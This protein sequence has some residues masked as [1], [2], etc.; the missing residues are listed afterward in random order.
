MVLDGEDG[1]A[2]EAQA[3]IGAVE[4]GDVSLLDA[5]RKGGGIDGKTMVHRDDLDLA[6]R[7]VLHR[8][9]GAV[10]ALMH[11]FG[12][13]AKRQAQH[14]VTEADAEDRN[15]GLDQFPDDRDG[16]FPSC[17]RVSR[18][19]RKEDSIRIQRKHIV[20]ARRR[21]HDGDLAVE[22]GEEAQDVTLHA[23]IDADDMVLRSVR[24]QFGSAFVPD[25][26]LFA[27]GGRLTRCRDLGEIE[28]F[29]AAPV[30]RHR[31]QR[32]DVELPVRIMSDNGIR[33]AVFADPGCQGAGVD[34][35]HADNPAGLQPR[36]EMAHG[37]V[38]GRIGDIGLEDDAHCAVTGRRREILDVFVI[39]A[40]IADMGEGEG[41]DLAE[42]GRVGQDFLIAGEGSVEAHFGRDCACRSDALAF[43]HGAV[44][45]DEHGGCGSGG[46]WSGHRR[47]P[48]AARRRKIGPPGRQASQHPVPPGACGR[49][50]QFGSLLVQVLDISARSRGVNLREWKSVE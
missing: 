46:P 38:V 23:I 26:G 15:V 28:T 27:P 33:G 22:P 7:V 11:L 14:L 4:Q 18:A 40:D 8:M 16:I 30:L 19:V 39:R 35:A 31:L 6:G 49:G 48:V 36:I 44:R 13:A 9:V 41:D 10:M 50:S 12:L 17:C 34:A 24:R 3:A 29:K 5:C 47:H 37:A 43:D 21:R 45:Q 2:R 32:V 42:I 25:P 20:L 1:L